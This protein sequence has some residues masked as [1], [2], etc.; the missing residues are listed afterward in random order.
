[1]KD[2]RLA[3]PPDGFDSRSADSGL[4]L[5]HEQHA[6]ALLH[7]NP[8]IFNALNALRA[9][10]EVE[11][12]ARVHH[13]GQTFRDLLGVNVFDLLNLLFAPQVVL[14]KME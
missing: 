3:L 9:T 6:S 4:D 7:E 1:M 11:P 2:A 14:R 8:E 5:A 10:Q 12:E 13:L